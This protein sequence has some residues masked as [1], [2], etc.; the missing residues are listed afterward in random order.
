[1]PTQSAA[2]FQTKLAT[3]LL[4]EYIYDHN[5][6]WKARICNAIHDELNME[7]IDELCDEYK[8]VLERCMKDGGNVFLKN[9]LFTMSC[10]AN[11]GE[12]WYEAK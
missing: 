7:V 2:A 3:C 8:E 5:H 6:L 10:S 4:F 1:M 12:S 11:I 9:N